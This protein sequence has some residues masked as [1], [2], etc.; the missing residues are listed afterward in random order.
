[1]KF[2]EFENITINYR[3]NINY[4]ETS[5]KHDVHQKNYYKL[6]NVFVFNDNNVI[7]INN[8]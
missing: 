1:M 8:H 6:I 7:E 4:V 5:I 3:D 2:V